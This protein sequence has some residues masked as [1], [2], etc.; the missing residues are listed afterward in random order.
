MKHLYY[1]MPKT[2]SH[3]IGTMIS[4]PSILHNVAGRG[5][6]GGQIVRIFMGIGCYVQ[7]GGLELRL[8]FFTTVSLSI[9]L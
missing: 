1:T 5:D 3:K 2:I 4:L 6:I 7:K 9:D 8:G